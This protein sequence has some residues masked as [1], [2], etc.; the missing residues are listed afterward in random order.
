MRTLRSPLGSWLSLVAAMLVGAGLVGVAQ[1][2]RGDRALLHS[3]HSDTMD[4]TL[5]AKNF[6]YKQPKLFRYTVPAAAFVP[7]SDSTVFSHTG[8][9][10][11]VAVSNFNEVVA[12][13]NLPLGAVVTKVQWFH[14]TSTTSGRLHLEA[15]DLAG[16]HLD[17]AKFRNPPACATQPCRMT[18]STIRRERIVANRHYGLWLYADS[19]TADAYKVVIFYRVRRPAPAT[20]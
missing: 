10:G 14:S 8:Y 1:G 12:P 16:S 9:S 17:M 3:G 5:T 13:V 11:L 7:N 18:D 4:G 19:G 20:S 2:H 15:N 6:E